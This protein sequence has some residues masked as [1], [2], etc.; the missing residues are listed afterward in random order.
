M[1]KTIIDQNL[2]ET[3][4]YINDTTQYNFQNKD[5]INID[6]KFKLELSKK[7]LEDIVNQCI[8]SNFQDN[9]NEKDVSNVS[10]TKIH[11]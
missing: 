9:L 8:T 10:E 1:T 6:I 7:E 3:L 4:K 2:Q 11:E 5:N